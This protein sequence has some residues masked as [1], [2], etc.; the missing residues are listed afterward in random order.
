MQRAAI[1]SFGASLCSPDVSTL[2]HK[3]ND[4]R[5]K[6]IGHKMWILIFFITFVSII[7]E[8]F[9]EWEMIETKPLSA[10]L[11]NILWYPVDAFVTIFTSGTKLTT[12][13]LITVPLWF[14]CFIYAKVH[15]LGYYATFWRENLNFVWSP[16]LA[17]NFMGWACLLLAGRCYVI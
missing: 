12:G 17:R 4:F 3:G 10:G 9:L 15:K 8:L 2:S 13:Y 7:A 11:Q 14:G 16:S 1:L 6:V 5:K